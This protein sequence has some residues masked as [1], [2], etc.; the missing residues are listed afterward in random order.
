MK[1]DGTAESMIAMAIWRGACPFHGI[2]SSFSNKN[3][4]SRNIL[5]QDFP[6]QKIP[7]QYLLQ[8]DTSERARRFFGRFFF[9]DISPSISHPHQFNNHR[10]TVKMTTNVALRAFLREA[11]TLLLVFPLSVFG[12][13][14]CVGSWTSCTACSPNDPA[15]PPWGV[16][17][18]TYVITTPASNGGASCANADGATSPFSCLTT[19]CPGYECTTSA[20]SKYGFPDDD[21]DENVLNVRYQFRSCAVEDASLNE[22]MHGSTGI[23]GGRFGNKE[24]AGG[25]YN[26]TTG[27]LTLEKRGGFASADATSYVLQGPGTL[28]T[29]FLD[30]RPVSPNPNYIGITSANSDFP[31]VT[32]VGNYSA[33]IRMRT[34]LESIYMDKNL[35]PGS[36]EGGNTART[37]THNTEET[38]AAELCH[39]VLTGKVLPPA[40]ITVPNEGVTISFVVGWDNTQEEAYE[41]FDL[42]EGYTLQYVYDDLYWLVRGSICT[43][44]AT[45]PTFIH[46]P[47][48][49]K[50]YKTTISNRAAPHP[51]GG[52]I[53]ST[54]IFFLFSCG[55]QSE[56]VSPPSSVLHTFSPSSPPRAII[57][58]R[59]PIRRRTRSGA[60]PARVWR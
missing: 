45:A 50:I 42:G 49:K 19:A 9:E 12:Q 59:V 55:E 20:S 56:F 58:T 14:D 3:K 57:S 34:G 31:S 48:P 10:S 25:S 17:T 39:D 60:G 6:F 23:L 4:K 16:K 30:L 46:R 22:V 26:Q 1:R 28:Y 2:V 15:T 40:P 27:I 41:L 43:P 21:A 51:H 36:A 11:I 29:T 8:Y 53:M 47:R 38:Q 54:T 18:C 52:C 37:S 24:V 13:T 44:I 5:F 32:L 33:C 35:A 7:L